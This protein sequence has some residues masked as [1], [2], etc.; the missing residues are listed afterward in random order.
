MQQQ[1]Q[2]YGNNNGE[3]RLRPERESFE[4]CLHPR[5]STSI[6]VGSPSHE[7]HRSD[8]HLHLDGPPGRAWWW[9]GGGPER[10]RAKRERCQW[11]QRGE[12]L[13]LLCIYERS[14]C[15]RCTDGCLVQAVRL[16]PTSI[17]LVSRDVCC[18]CCCCS[19]PAVSGVIKDTGMLCWLPSCNSKHHASD[20][21]EKHS[22]GRRTPVSCGHLLLS[23]LRYLARAGR[24]C[25][26]AADDTSRAST[27][28]CTSF[29]LMLGFL[30][31]VEV[32]AVVVEPARLMNT[33]RFGKCTNY[34]N[35][36][37]SSERNGHRSQ[38]CPGGGASSGDQLLK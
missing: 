27:E 19:G 11:W 34:A 32:T 23:K 4:R 37:V 16:S 35:K 22:R 7:R 5:E 18:C 31:H 29:S 12:C 13:L 36:S 2:R 33:A 10:E 20:S 28:S 15:V 21:W 30:Q 14:A 3:T 8:R 26:H 9:W 6:E 25:E 1:R 24:V 38:W 17:R